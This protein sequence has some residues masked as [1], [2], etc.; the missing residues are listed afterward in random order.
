MMKKISSDNERPNLKRIFYHQKKHHFLDFFNKSKRPKEMQG[1]LLVL[2]VI[3]KAETN[4][5]DRKCFKS[6]EITQLWLV[7][8]NPNF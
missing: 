5:K 6:I 3:L 7:L 1:I 8:K 4:Q 2:S